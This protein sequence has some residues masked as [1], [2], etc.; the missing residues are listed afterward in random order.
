MRQVVEDQAPARAGDAHQA[1]R[2]VV[3]SIGSTDGGKPS[4]DTTAVRLG[5]AVSFKLH[6]S[7]PHCTQRGEAETDTDTPGLGQGL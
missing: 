4:G 3:G 6:L 7:C 5:Q 1:G 2:V